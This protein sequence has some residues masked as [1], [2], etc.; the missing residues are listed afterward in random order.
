MCTPWFRLVLLTVSTKASMKQAVSP[1]APN[2]LEI[3]ALKNAFFPHKYFLGIY[4]H[5]SA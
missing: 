5:V 4:L 3:C 2:A 1:L